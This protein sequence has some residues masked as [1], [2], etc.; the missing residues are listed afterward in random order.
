MVIPGIKLSHFVYTSA[1]GGTDN[2]VITDKMLFAAVTKRHYK[3]RYYIDLLP[4][5]TLLTL[6]SFNC[7][8]R[9]LT[10]I[11]NHFNAVMATNYVH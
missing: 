11:T 9:K 1:D 7:L 4:L 2:T 5:Q 8:V 6:I 10:S 3:D